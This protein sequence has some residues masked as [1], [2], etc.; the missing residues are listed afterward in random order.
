M[1]EFVI[2]NFTLP[3]GVEEKIRALL[4]S[5]FNEKY[6]RFSVARLHKTHKDLKNYP[7]EM[8]IDFFLVEYRNKACRERVKRVNQEDIDF[9]NAKCIPDMK[10]MSVYLKNLEPA[11]NYGLGEV[12]ILKLIEMPRVG[13]RRSLKGAMYRQRMEKYAQRRRKSDPQEKS[14]YDWLVHNNFYVVINEENIVEK[15]MR[16]ASA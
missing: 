12:T 4:G 13:R 10:A 8:V 15:E 9:I 16:Y 3:S 14:F 11:E 5:D 6:Y 2:C 1:S 7:E